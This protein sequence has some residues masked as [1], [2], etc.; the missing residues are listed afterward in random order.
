MTEAKQLAAQI[1]M[2]FTGPVWIDVTIMDTLKN[3]SAAQA[4]AKPFNNANSIWQIV[5]HC[6]DWRF[7]LCERI[8]GKSPMAGEANYFIPV[9]NTTEKAWKTTLKEF[10]KSQNELVKLVKAMSDKKLN[11]EQGKYKVTFRNF[12]HGIIQHDA[13]HLG[14]IVILKKFV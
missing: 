2:L 9:K 6:I 10:E 5:N 11:T 13:Y 4:A 1:E 12:I 8:Q 7:N 3:I 14:Q